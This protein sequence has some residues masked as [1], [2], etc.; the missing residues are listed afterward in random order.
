MCE[1]TTFDLSIVHIYH[2]LHHVFMQYSTNNTTATKNQL[3]IKTRNKMF[4]PTVLIMK[5]IV[6]VKPYGVTVPRF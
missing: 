5:P 2:P 4:I 3:L 6:V 1:N